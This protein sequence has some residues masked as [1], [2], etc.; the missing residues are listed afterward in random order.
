VSIHVGLSLALSGS[1]DNVL[2]DSQVGGESGMTIFDSAGNRLLR[3]MF[4]NRSE[5]ITLGGARE[6]F[7]ANNSFSLGFGVP[8]IF[9][10]SADASVIVRNEIRGGIWFLD[11]DANRIERNDVEGSILS[12]RAAIEIGGG[13]GN[14]VRANSI[15]GGE[16]GI[17]VRP[18]ASA[19]RIVGNV[20]NA[21]FDDGIHVDAP[22]TLVR[23]NTANDNGDLGI[24]AI[25]GTIDGGG[26]RASGNGNPLQCVNVVC[27]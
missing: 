4:H 20:A 6:T 17:A 23:A 3:N 13:D 19:T 2:R 12:S 7:I 11:G 27:R 18:G 24:E 16:G 25:G 14:L 8:S 9:A 10:F 21:F 1:N 22:G 15:A 26:N 5:A